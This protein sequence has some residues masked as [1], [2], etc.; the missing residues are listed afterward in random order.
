MQ[1]AIFEGALVAKYHCFEYCKDELLSEN[2]N[3]HIF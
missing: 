1:N 2:G 3:V